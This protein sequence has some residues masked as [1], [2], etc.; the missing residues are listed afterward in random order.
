MSLDCVNC[1]F[2]V[3]FLKSKWS[4]KIPNM[5][6]LGIVMKIILKLFSG[7]W[8]IY[9]AAARPICAVLQG[10]ENVSADHC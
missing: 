3:I 1:T 10:N 6:V 7:V 4:N 2:L 5:E 8:C 9:Y